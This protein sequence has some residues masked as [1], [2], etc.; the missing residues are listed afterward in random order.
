MGCDVFICKFCSH[1]FRYAHLQDENQA[2]IRG[3]PLILGSVLLSD[4]QV[5]VNSSP[6]VQT[7]WLFVG[8]LCGAHCAGLAVKLGLGYTTW[9]DL[10]VTCL[11]P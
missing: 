4:A 7:P 3:F 5:D 2:A 9:C 1:S 10:L 11:H 8:E 6:L